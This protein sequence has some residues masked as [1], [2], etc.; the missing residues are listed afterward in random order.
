MLPPH[1]HSYGCTS[2]V[3]CRAHQDAH[4]NTTPCRP[5]DGCRAPAGEVALESWNSLH[6]RPASEGEHHRRRHRT[7]PQ[8]DRRQNTTPRCT[9]GTAPAGPFSPFTP[10]HYAGCFFDYC[11]LKYVQNDSF[12]RQE[13]GV[14]TKL[15]EACP[16]RHAAHGRRGHAGATVPCLP[17]QLTADG[18]EALPH[19]AQGGSRS[20][21]AADLAEQMCTSYWDGLYFIASYSSS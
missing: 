11:Y 16:R 2:A 21:G 19:A 14:S 8:R 9:W 6:S 18:E 5:G 10:I 4:G 17:S 13:E 1:G 12:F 7:G 3:C 20:V 15:A